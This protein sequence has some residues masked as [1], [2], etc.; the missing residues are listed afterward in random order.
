MTEP[1]N[2]PHWEMFVR[3]FNRYRKKTAIP[4]E[5]EAAWQL[6]TTSQH[7]SGRRREDLTGQRFGKLTATEYVG[8]SYWLCR[9]DCGELT[10]AVS[11]HLKGGRHQSCG[12]NHKGYR[13]M[14]NKLKGESA[15]ST[16]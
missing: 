15:C 12:C 13:A 1:F 5:L 6:L 11:W 16:A 14:W 9:G 10:K 2:R 4:P 8:G 7:I 3:R